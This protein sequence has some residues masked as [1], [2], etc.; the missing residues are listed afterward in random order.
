MDLT[1]N[2]TAIIE[3][4]LD[5]S[6]FL[7]GPAGSGKTT[8]AVER[9]LYLMQAG[10]PGSSILLVVPQRTLAEP[11]YQALQTPGVTAG[12]LVTVVTIG[13]LARRMV[14]LFW[15][16]VS[17]ES[18][19]AHPDRPPTF[20]TLE[21][22]QYYMAYLV[23]PLLEQGYFDSVTIDRNRLY[24]QILDN[25]N[26]SAVVGFPHSEIGE[27]LKTAWAG[28]PGQARVYEDAQACAS[29]F[30]EYCLANN[31]L[32]FS[33]QMEI[34]Q[35]H[36][37]SQPLCRN[38]LQR[39]Y[40]HLIVD[41]IE[42]DTP[43]A[44]DLLLDWL[45]N[46]A[47]VLVVYDQDAGYRQFLGADP[48]SAYRL[49]ELC[50]QQIT[51]EHS[52]VASPAAQML[53]QTLVD[54][55]HYRAK[56]SLPAADAAEAAP[57]PLD[58]ITY[59]STRDSHLDSGREGSPEG[60]RRSQRFFP[61]MIDWVAARI[62]ALVK[63]EGIPPG[64][65]AVL[66]PFL[67]DAL[68]FALTNRLDDYGIAYRSHRPSRSLR[69]EPTARCLLTL[70]A[71]AHPEW[72]LGPA[73]PDLV[74]ALLQSI[75]GLDLVRAQLLVDIVYRTRQGEA[76]LSSFDLIRPEMQTRIT[77]LLGERFERLRL[78]IE[79]Y[80]QSPALE[81]DHFLSRLFGEVL[82]QP[83]FGFHGDT[84]GDTIGESSREYSRSF[85]AG[86]VAAN[87]I[88]S[89]QKFR[90]AVGDTLAQENV[91][92]G[93]E[94]LLMVQDGVIAAQYVRS[95][96]TQREDST[97]Q[98]GAV[99]LAP[100][101]TFLMSNRPVAIQFWL[102][103]GSKAW[104]ERL[105]QPLT[106][107]HVLSRRWSAGKAWTADDELAAAIQSLSQLVLGLTRRCREQIF[108]GLSDLNE[109]GYELRGPLLLALQRILRQYSTVKP[110]R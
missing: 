28:D 19:F 71:L 65:I 61:Q 97:A 92:L 69:E 98:A 43:A 11:Y 91:P 80:H 95:W 55:L 23:R 58:A 59:D 54:A 50:P 12:G 35:H 109:Q 49:K 22:A 93:R 78:W 96:Q 3:A 51:L 37:W 105:Y 18:G 77:Y 34:F 84:I 44:H 8:A 42:E 82:S 39:T 41:N 45:P 1:P 7:E 6:I 76:S 89:I 24:S 14:E 64:E 27:R 101:Y 90:W 110:S 107:P 16:M 10:V 15:P 13:G 48:E 67:S 86:E 62:A 83:G 17:R 102:D 36:L 63:E 56:P 94:Y 66:A 33:L 30:R 70:A 81:M 104:F 88:E 32:D 87:L 75:N 21:T 52:F 99:L 2:Q 100:A 57:S 103:A 5:A 25:L 4:P 60:N 38:Y 26:K 47:S 73:K 68:R 9:M 53:G 20:L 72:E 108:L 40:R 46:C 74:Y 85:N 31:L 106:H 79:E 29:L